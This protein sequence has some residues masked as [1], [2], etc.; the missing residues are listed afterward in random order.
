MEI[1]AATNRKSNKSYIGYTMYTLNER[2]DQHYRDARGGSDYHF[3][4]ALRKYKKTDWIWVTL[5]TCNNKDQSLNEEI[6]LIAE[7]GTYENG[8]NSTPGGEGGGGPTSEATKRLISKT[9][10]GSK[11][12]QEHINNKAA[13]H[14]GT[15]HGPHTETTKAKISASKKGVAWTE[16]RWEAHRQRQI[17]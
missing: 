12:T 6:K 13:S 9:L 15:I 11:Q 17:T 4:R 2:R 5:T 14:R 7:Y 1:Y 10:T 16:A 8:Y 3:H